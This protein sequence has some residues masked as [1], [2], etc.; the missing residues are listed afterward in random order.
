MVALKQRYRQGMRMRQWIFQATAA[1]LLA[2][3][4]ACSSTPSTTGASDGMK[5]FSYRTAPPMDEPPRRLIGNISS[6]STHDQ[7]AWLWL[8]PG[9][10][11]EHLRTAG[12]QSLENVTPVDFPWAEQQLQKA[13]AEL[14]PGAPGGIMLKAA[15]VEMLP[16]TKLLSRLSPGFDEL[17]YIEIELVF[18]ETDGGRSLGALI[19][20]ARDKDFA[21]ALNRLI[22]DLRA[23]FSPPAPDAPAQ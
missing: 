3:C 23:V 6:L 17:P 5:N 9:I 20:Y 14:F 2:A 4:C 21:V 11:L 15:I 13:L 16:R 7:V 18:A 8:R 19:H 12:L 1:A 22:G 10:S